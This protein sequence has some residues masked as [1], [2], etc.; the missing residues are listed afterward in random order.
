M[1]EHQTHNNLKVVSTTQNQPY[2]TLDIQYEKEHGLAW[3]F[4]H[5]EPRPCVTAQLVQDINAW[6]DTCCHSDEFDELRYMV[7][8]SK[9]DG[10]FNLGGD[11]DL[12]CRLIR[13]RDR[14]AIYQY[15]V[16][17]IDTLLRNYQGLNRDVTTISLI[18]GDA[19]GG[20]LEYALS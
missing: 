3:Y 18:Q 10:I 1:M 11:L 8:A 16:S 2:S 13:D 19:L 5:P 4:T 15:A 17:C 6:F 7:V 9:R 14:N 20:G 12:F